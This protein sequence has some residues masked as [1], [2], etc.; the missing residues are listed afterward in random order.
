MS[1][2][3]LPTLLAAA[4]LSDYLPAKHQYKVNLPKRLKF[5]GFD[6]GNRHIRYEGQRKMDVFI[7]GC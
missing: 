3:C 5:S 6:V 1:V 7:P 4:P 2:P